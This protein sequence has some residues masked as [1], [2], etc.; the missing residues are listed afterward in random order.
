MKK[1]INFYNSHTDIQSFATT[2][3]KSQMCWTIG[4]WS[5]FTISSII[6]IGHVNRRFLTVK[7]AR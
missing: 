5:Y 1:I 3:R 4:G 6:A 2:L 7:I